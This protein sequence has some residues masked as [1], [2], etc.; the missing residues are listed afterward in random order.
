M[1][2]L[3]F[4]TNKH[5]IPVANK[6]LIYYPIEAIA[7]AG[8]KEV[9]ITYNP[10][11]LEFVKK[12]LGT[13]RKWGVKFKY[14]LQR[15]PKGLADIVRSCKEELNGDPF[16]LHLG[17]NI[18]TDGVKDA[19][20]YFKKNKPNG[21]VYRV[22]HKENWRLG[23]PVFDKR[24]RLIKYV[25]KP[26][27]P[28]N[29]FAIPGF[30]LAD[31]NFFKAFKGKD[32]VSPSDRGEWEIPDPFQWMI[33]HDYRVD[34][35]EYKGKWLDPGKFDDWIESNRFLLDEKLEKEISGRVDKKSKIE[36][37][38]HSGKRCKIKNSEIRGPVSVG[39]KVQIIN[40]YVGPYTS[41]DD[42]CV[43]ENSHVENSVLMKDVTIRNIKQPISESLI[44]TG[45]EVVDED[46]PTDWIKLFIGEKSRV[47]I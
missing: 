15:E 36:G 20:D 29:D 22:Q 14:V 37:R 27:K 7:G 3:T 44:G 12:N 5:F 33:D 40:S 34:V 45:A 13:G 19:I 42:K 6:P 41:I 11:W 17:D 35:I 9:L 8:V 23:V 46:G 32:A 16:A 38:V 39:E 47:R 25:E 28:P 26:K 1:Q 30:Y 31:N 21:L 43:I 4:S 2:P 18:F 10:G 24:D